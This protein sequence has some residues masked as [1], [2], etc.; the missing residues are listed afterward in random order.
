MKRVLALFSAFLM[1]FLV[2][3]SQGSPVQAAEV[4]GEECGCHELQPLT[5][6]ERNKI[7]STLL[8]SNEFKAVKAELKGANYQWDGAHAIEV[9]QPGPS[10]TLAGTYFSDQNGT[11]MV[12]AFILMNGNIVYGGLQPEEGKHQH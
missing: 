9:V 11:R 8:K 4:P 2:L 12:A 7:V 6:S 10:M 1:I 3:D 5:G